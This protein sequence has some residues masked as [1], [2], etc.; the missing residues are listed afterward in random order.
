MNNE[1]SSSIVMSLWEESGGAAMTAT[2]L[3][4][5]TLNWNS[6]P[7]TCNGIEPYILFELVSYP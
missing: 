4:A 1:V 2:I 6:W 5:G 3:G 7:L